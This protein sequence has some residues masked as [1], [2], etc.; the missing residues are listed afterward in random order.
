MLSEYELNGNVFL[1][2]ST[3]HFSYY[4]LTALI[5]SDTLVKEW[6]EENFFT[7]SS[8]CCFRSCILQLLA[9]WLSSLSTYFA[10]REA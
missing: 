6:W 9:L 3:T 10:S 5:V 8:L 2:P 1:D 4:I 7:A